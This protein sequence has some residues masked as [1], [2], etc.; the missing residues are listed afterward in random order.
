[1]LQKLKRYGVEGG[2]LLWCTDYLSGGFGKCCLVIGPSYIV[3]SSGRPTWSSSICS[4]YWK[5]TSCEWGEGSGV[6]ISDKLTWDPH[7]HLITAKADKL[8]GLLKSK[9]S[10]PMLTKVAVR[11]SLKLS[12]MFETPPLLRYRN[13]VSCS[14]VT[15]TWGWASLD[16]CHRMDF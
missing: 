9:R 3:S 13:L 7:L 15:K 12:S 2:T 6:V 1:M 11:K 5:V 4:L 10:C 8:L 14:E 16:A